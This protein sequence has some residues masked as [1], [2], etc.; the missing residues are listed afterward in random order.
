V[1]P[2]SCIGEGFA[3]AEVAVLVAAL[4]RSFSFDLSHPE[5]ALSVIWGVSVTPIGLLFRMKR[6]EE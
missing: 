6:V 4:V 1:G 3:K 5:K 2:R